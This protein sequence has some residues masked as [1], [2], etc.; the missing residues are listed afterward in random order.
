[1]EEEMGE[2]EEDMV[3]VEVEVDLGE[4][5]KGRLTSVTHTGSRSTGCSRTSCRSHRGTRGRGVGEEVSG[6]VGE[7]KVE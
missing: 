5:R 6:V 4:E 2:E 3:K 1:M 7:E